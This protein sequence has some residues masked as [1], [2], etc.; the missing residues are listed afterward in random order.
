MDF[1][2]QVTLILALGMFLDFRKAK[3]HSPSIRLVFLLRFLKV[4]QHPVCR[5]KSILHGNPYGIPL[6]ITNVPKWDTGFLLWMVKLQNLV[7]NRILT[8]N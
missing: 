7:S 8:K 3:K 1:F 4:L 5:D 2:V 6:M